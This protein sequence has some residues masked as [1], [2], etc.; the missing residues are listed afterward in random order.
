MLYSI[1]VRFNRLWIFSQSL[2]RMVYCCCFAI[3]V[4][5][6]AALAL[7]TTITGWWWWCCWHCLCL[8]FPSSPHRHCLHNLCISCPLVWHTHFASYESMKF[9]ILLPKCHAQVAVIPKSR[10][11]KTIWWFGII[12]ARCQIVCGKFCI[13]IWCFCFLYFFQTYS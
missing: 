9:Q 4:A 1:D 3:A 10:I 5:V 13:D 8:S 11:V 2:L 7:T 6:A 12:W